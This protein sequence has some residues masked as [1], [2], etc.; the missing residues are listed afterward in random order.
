MRGHSVGLSST[1]GRNTAEF[2]IGGKKWEVNSPS[3]R[4]AAQS[5]RGTSN[6][7]RDR[8]T[9]TSRITYKNSILLRNLKDASITPKTHFQGATNI[10]M[11]DRSKY[12]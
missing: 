11:N 7:P 6:S 12:K 3:H 2:A 5:Y 8:E 10:F 1:M 9:A 4:N